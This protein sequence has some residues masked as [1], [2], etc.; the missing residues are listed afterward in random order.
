MPLPFIPLILG[1][2]AAAT[3]AVGVK[4]GLDA[5]SDFSKAKSLNYEAQAMIEEAGK[6]LEKRRAKAQSHISSLA[7]IKIDIYNNSLT[8]FV[9]DFRKIK[10]IDFSELSLGNEL[11]LDKEAFVAIE[12]ATI[13]MSEMLSGGVTALGSSAITG[14]ALWGGISTF[15]VASTGTAIG[16]LSGVAATNATLAWLGGGSLAAGGFGIAGGTLVLGG[17]VAGPALAVGGFMLANKAEEALH[18]AYANKSKAEEEAEKMKLAETVV[19][20]I[21]KRCDEF[22]NVLWNLRKPFEENLLQFGELVNKNNDYKT[23]ARSEKEFVRMVFTQAEVIK[24]ILDIPIITEKGELS[25][26]SSLENVH[27]LTDKIGISDG[28]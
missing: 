13:Q 5:K 26:E 22:T 1:G 11:K 14:V 12:N 2:V 16:T 25:E 10:N 24:K 8:S 3:A 9:N 18:N 28:K 23:Y 17:L 4:K 15:G 6:S 19:K 7:E 21:S 27:A 20:A